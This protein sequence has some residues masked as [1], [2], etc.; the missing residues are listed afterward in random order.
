MG[1]SKIAWGQPGEMLGGNLQ[2][3]GIPSTGSRNTPGHFTLQKPEMSAGLMGLL[4]RPFLSGNRLYL[5]PFKFNDF[6]V[7][8]KLESFSI[9]PMAFPD[10]ANIF[11]LPNL[12]MA[13][14]SC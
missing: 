8:K 5:S 11:W 12:V 13:A 14:Q 6:R 4:A 7:T 1:T 9:F 10:C 2:W 3:T